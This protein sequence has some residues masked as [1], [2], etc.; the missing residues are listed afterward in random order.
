V[1]D[2]GQFMAM[3]FNDLHHLH[4]GNLVRYRLRLAEY[5]AWVER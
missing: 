1:E 3:V 2:L 4:E 5:H